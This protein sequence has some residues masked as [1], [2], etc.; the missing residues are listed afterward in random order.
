MKIG[1]KTFNDIEILQYFKDKCDFIEVQAIQGNNYSFLK[2]FTIPIVIHAEH[3]GFGINPAN[4]LLYEKNLKSTNF[5]IKT[6]DLCNAKKIIIHPGNLVDDGCSLENSINFINKFKD[7]RIIIENLV[8][9]KGSL[10]T[11]PESLKSFLKK[12]DKRFCFDIN[13]AIAT[14]NILKKEQLGFLKDFIK[15]KPS[16]FHLGGQKKHS[17]IDNHLIFKHS[18]INIKEILG[19]LPKSAEITIET[20]PYIEDKK[21][22]LIII[23]DILRELKLSNI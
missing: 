16:H 21:E 7:N 4:K 17:L 9:N 5:A 8:K 22:D 18:E 20:T 11:T 2:N 10:C 14:A 13:H 23:K 15:L 12:T 19:I 1:V 6:A 3:I